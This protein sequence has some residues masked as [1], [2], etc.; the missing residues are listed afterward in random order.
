MISIVAFKKAN[1]PLTK[2]ISLDG[3]AVRSD[4]SFAH[5][6]G[7]YELRYDA[8]AVRARMERST[9]PIDTMVKCAIAAELDEVE[10]KQLIDEAARIARV[11]VRS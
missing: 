11:G 3:D 2:R 8:S 7:S 10:E 6:G 5:G 1:G 9:N 4:H